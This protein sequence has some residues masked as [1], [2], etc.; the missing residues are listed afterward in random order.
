M[1]NRAISRSVAG[2][3]A[4]LCMAGPAAL[5][6]CSVRH[7]QPYTPRE[8]QWEEPDYAATDSKRPDGSLWSEATPSLFE[9]HRARRVGD[10]VVIEIDEDTAARG[11]A[12]TNSA[13]D[14]ESTASITG[15]LGLVGAISRAVPDLDL[16]NLMGMMSESEFVGDAQTVRRNKVR[17][18]ISVHVRRVLPNGDMYVEGH[19][20]VLVNNEELHLY[21]SGV[22][23]PVDVS[24]DNVVWS[25]RVADAQVEL[26]GRGDLSDNQRPG[27]L[28][29][30]WN[31][32]NPI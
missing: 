31:K 18:T 27:W 2:A 28:T 23:R 20:V 12:S 26:T 15:L 19:K 29:R 13:R 7:I 9:D 22:V 8:R 21:I 6:A 4:A 16:E 32:V 5:T 10:T 3:I 14:S 17:G 11:D 30:I 1:R 24:Q 25:S